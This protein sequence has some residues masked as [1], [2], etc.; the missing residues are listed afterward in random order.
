[1]LR[2]LKDL[3]LDGML[4]DVGLL[5]SVMPQLERLGVIMLWNFI[6]LL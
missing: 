5:L 1:M 4:L 3:D 2:S 6:P